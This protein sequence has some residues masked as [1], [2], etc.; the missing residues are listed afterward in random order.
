M[1]LSLDSKVGKVIGI[2][3]GTS[4]SCVGVYE[5]S[6]VEIIANRQGMKITPSYVAFTETGRL[7]GDTAK[8]QFAANP[9]NTIFDAKRLIGRKYDEKVL[10]GTKTWPFQIVNK[11]ERPYVKVVCKG[12]TRQFAPEEISAF[13]LQELKSTAESYLGTAVTR[14]VVTV[15]AYFNNTQRQATKD[16]CAIAGLIV[17][18]I[19]SAPTAAAIAYGVDKIK[20]GSNILVYDLGAGKIDVSIL[21]LEDGVFEVLATQGNTYLGGQNF[22]ER[23]ITYLQNA[24]LKK[25]KIDITNDPSA[26]AKLRTEVEKAKILLSS[27]RQVQIDIENLAEGVD[28]SETLTRTIFQDMNK[29]LFDMTIKYLAD[30]LNDSGLS[31]KEIDEI[32]LV[33]GSARIPKI[34]TLVRDFLGT[35]ELNM[36]INP[37]K[38][39]AHGA[40]VYGGVLSE[41]EKMNIDILLMDVNPLTV[42]ME[43][44]GGVMQGLISKNSVL[45]MKEC[46]KFT[47]FQ[48]NQATI[49]LRVFQ[50]ENSMVR[51]NVLVGTFELSNISPAPLGFPQIDVTFT[52]DV[53]GILNVQA[54]DK[55]TSG[56]QKITITA[57]VNRPSDEEIKRMIISATQWG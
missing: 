7:V 6:K 22:N 54:V 15:P 18:R 33:G 12:E 2:D 53:N 31:K 52:I 13:V 5:N 23:V 49:S 21:H 1:A 47:T 16:A 37:D 25:H 36:S 11:D 44:K 30:A 10:A 41:D 42:G 40:A 3:L 48:D 32:I 34:Q 20:S 50:G 28:F 35:M 56:E 26:L 46:Q 17:E 43:T 9:T 57:D 8:Q 27:E 51:N 38:A 14:A 55:N 29:D 45:P 39:V 24:F 4:Y 19:L